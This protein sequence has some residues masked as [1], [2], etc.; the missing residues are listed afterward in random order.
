MSGTGPPKAPF[1]TEPSNQQIG[2]EIEDILRSPD[3]GP[4]VIRGGAI[5]GLGYTLGVLFTAVAS[6]FLL[7][8]LGVSDFG[9]YVTVLSLI[10][11][12]SGVTDAGLTAVGA[13]DL[14]LRPPGESR[15]RL[16]A[17]L[18]GLRLVL[19]P[20]GVGCAVLFALAAGY[21]R[22]LV[23]GTLLA[24]V[25]LILINAQATL[26][27]P[28]S[29]ELRIARLTLADVLKQAVA[30]AVIGL[31]VA[32]GASLLPFF[33][34]Q[35][36]VGTIVLG[37]TPW[38]VGRRG[39]VAPTYDRSEWLSILREALPIA[40]FLVMNVLYFRV[41]IILMSLLAAASAT[42]LFATSFR[43][44]EILFGLP[45]LV[46]SVAL[47]VLATAGA[48]RERLR[49]QLQRMS[50]VGLIASAYLLL[51]VVVLA[52]PLIRLIGGS[53]YVAAAPLL[54]IQG[55]ALLAVFFGQVWQLG[56][57][58]IRRQSAL[59][60]ANGV[61]L[62]LV[63][64]LGLVLIPPFDEVG[65]AI[66]AVVG[67]AV[68][69][70]MLLF[71]LARADRTLVPRFGFAWKVGVAA[72]VAAS[73]FLLPLPPVGAAVLATALFVAGIWLTGALPDEVREAFLR[74]PGH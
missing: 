45:A 19:T 33:A 53:E 48:E 18:I 9:R 3:A 72:V 10:A 38:L 47:P 46:L 61:A 71:V 16:L 1:G 2:A 27:L 32:A 67:E 7:R 42:G 39:F 68:L 65:A 60:V 55:V 74:S 41:L 28:L 24:G 14:A 63:L 70:V 69:A 62:A 15:R 30:V 49:Y 54:R 5:R 56:L 22:T 23:L 59:A 43:I 21:D 13:R 12:V 34:A 31:L 66:A 26:M 4:R 25:G 20:I 35:V 40:V 64:V 52:E 6:V 17:N 57:I 51:M 58:A 11:I 29:V 44:Y 8:Y 36:V 50:E 37:V 73:G